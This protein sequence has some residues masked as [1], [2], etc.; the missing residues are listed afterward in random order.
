MNGMKCRSMQRFPIYR[1]FSPAPSLEESMTN[2]DEADPTFLADLMSL[3]GGE[4]V[5]W[6]ADELASIWRHQLAAPLVHDL[7]AVSPDA[8]TI[9]TRDATIHSFAQLMNLPQPPTDLLR[10]MKGFA[11]AENSAETGLPSKITLA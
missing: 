5:V 7:A 3:A 1:E 10:L 4:P 11:K 8:V 9:L 6:S 2:P